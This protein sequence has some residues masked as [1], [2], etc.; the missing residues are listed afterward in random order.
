MKLSLIHICMNLIIDDTDHPLIIKVASIQSARMQVYFIDNDDYFQNRLQVCLLYTSCPLIEIIITSGTK[1]V[2]I[3]P[4]L[5]V[6]GL[7]HPSS[8]PFERTVDKQVYDILPLIIRIDVYKRQ[9]IVGYP[10]KKKDTTQQSKNFHRLMVAPLRS[11]LTRISQ[12]ADTREKNSARWQRNLHLPE[13]RHHLY[14]QLL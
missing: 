4:T 12:Q 7:H 11:T 9:D 13:L 8:I 3:I 14:R 2:R 6:R 5:P 10:P 1:I